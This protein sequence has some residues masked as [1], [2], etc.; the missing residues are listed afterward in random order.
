LDLVLFQKLAEIL[1]ED[2]L[3]MMLL[4]RGYILPYRIHHAGADCEH[5]LT[6]LPLKEQTQW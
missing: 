3:A 5:R 4:L 2:A 6:L 1:F